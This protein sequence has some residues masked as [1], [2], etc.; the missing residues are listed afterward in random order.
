[1]SK[2]RAENT[3]DRLFRRE[4]ASA[5]ETVDLFNLNGQADR[6]LLPRVETERPTRQ[7]VD[8]ELKLNFMLDT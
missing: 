8:S 7:T 3:V 5:K 1:M 2:N 6:P 4:L